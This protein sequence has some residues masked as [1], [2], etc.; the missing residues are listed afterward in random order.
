MMQSF[1][2]QNV[3]S[4]SSKHHLPRFVFHI[5]I[6]L[7]GN[8]LRGYILQES[9]DLYLFPG[10]S[11]YVGSNRVALLQNVP[12]KFPWMVRNLLQSDRAC[13]QKS[14]KIVKPLGQMQNTLQV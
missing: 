10:V 8:R 3:K 11:P 5:R 13:L 6:E 7:T 12:V 2:C 9:D 1:Y 14:R 4:L